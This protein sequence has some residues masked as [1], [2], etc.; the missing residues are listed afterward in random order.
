M[1]KALWY[2]LWHYQETITTTLWWPF[3]FYL[4]IAAFASSQPFGVYRIGL[5]PRME[6]PCL[7]RSAEPISM[8][9]LLDSV[10]GIWPIL[11]QTCLLEL[12]KKIKLFCLCCGSYWKT[13]FF[14]GQCSEAVRSGRTWSS[15]GVEHHTGT[16]DEVDMMKSSTR[17]QEPP[18]ANSATDHISENISKPIA[19]EF[20]TTC[21][22]KNSHVPWSQ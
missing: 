15:D 6:G 5:L 20:S 1:G 13:L 16:G 3:S 18:E 21:K 14:P 8:A 2:I 4:G 12:L 19:V 9:I 17:S 10:V 7:R 22:Y 11:G